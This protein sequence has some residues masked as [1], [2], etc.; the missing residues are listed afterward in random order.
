MGDL[1]GGLKETEGPGDASGF[2]KYFEKLEH[3]SNAA[4]EQGKYYF[5]REHAL[6]LFNPTNISVRLSEQNAHP[7]LVFGVQNSSS[8]S[9]WSEESICPTR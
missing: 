2:Q 3:D 6:L 8:I 9:T 4:I 1:E 7:E 5:V